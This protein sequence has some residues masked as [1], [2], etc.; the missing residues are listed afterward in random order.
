MSFDVCRVVIGHKNLLL[1]HQQTS[2]PNSSLSLIPFNH[3]LS[4]WMTYSNQ[5]RLENSTLACTF[6]PQQTK[7]SITVLSENFGSR[8]TW[9]HW[10]VRG[11]DYHCSI[12][13]R[14]W[15]GCHIFFLP[16]Y[17]R[18]EFESALLCLS[19]STTA[20]KWI[21]CHTGFPFSSFNVSTVKPSQSL[22]SALR[23]RDTVG[24]ISLR[25]LW[26]TLH[27][28]NN[29][30]PVMLCQYP[31]AQDGCCYYFVISTFRREPQRSRCR[32]PECQLMTGQLEKSSKFV[33]ADREPWWIWEGLSIHN[34]TGCRRS[35]SSHDTVDAQHVAAGIK[36]NVLTGYIVIRNNLDRV[37]PVYYFLFCINRVIPSSNW[38]HK[39]AVFFV[40]F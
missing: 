27:N 6:V 4:H 3:F 11:Y 22:P 32:A 16:N 10:M 34:T 15:L 14:G 13:T 26:D 33:T 7:M 28:T 25:Y 30:V 19:N 1:F 5:N 36:F 39:T 35:F 31:R 24:V 17:V 9:Y 18:F 23:N 37:K 29:L 2:A 40:A 8:P 12:R 38:W 21:F 20:Y